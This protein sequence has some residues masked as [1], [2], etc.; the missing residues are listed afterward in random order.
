MRLV[1]AV[2]A[3]VLLVSGVGVLGASTAQAQLYPHPAG[4]CVLTPVNPNPSIN[5]QTQILLV[6]TDLNGNPV[7]GVAS[8]ATVA[9]QPGQGA[10][11]TLLESSTAALQQRSHDIRFEVTSQPTGT[12]PSQA[13]VA[14]ITF[15]TDENGQ[16]TLVLTTGDTPGVIKIQSVCGEL[17]ANVNIPIGQ[18]PGPPNTG[19]GFDSGLSLGTAVLAMGGLAAA[20]LGL[21]GVIAKRRESRS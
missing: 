1:R 17:S 3:S 15:T 10:G 19:T 9:S 20:A 4:V 18:P 11:I 5:A 8:S 14:P 21:T 6:L 16:A 12:A 13:A 7:A 2:L